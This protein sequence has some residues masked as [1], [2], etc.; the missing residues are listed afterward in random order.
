MRTLIKFILCL[1]M[2]VL[3]QIQAFAGLEITASQEM[4][5]VP[6]P[7]TNVV[8][9]KIE[10]NMARMDIGSDLSVITLPDESAQI[11]LFCIEQKKIV[12]GTKDCRCPMFDGNQ[13]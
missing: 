12:D 1:A 8:V 2:I 10:T 7:L 9:T 11:Q 13:N 4:Q 5:G 3:W 6:I